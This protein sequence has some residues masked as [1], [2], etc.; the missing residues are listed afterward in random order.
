MGKKLM[1]VMSKTK[2]IIP[3]QYS[4]FSSQAIVLNA[5]TMICRLQFLR[6]VD[7]IVNNHGVPNM[8]RM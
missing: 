8:R 4:Y 5:L 6:C 3:F 2:V 7:R 1:D